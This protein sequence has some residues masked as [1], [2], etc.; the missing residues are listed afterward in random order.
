MITVKAPGKL[1]IA[2]EYAV[3]ETGYPSI[4][5][6]LDQFVTVEISRSKS[7][8]S[9]VSK[10]YRD[11]SVL[12]RRQGDQMILDNRD[13]T[14]NYIISAIRLTEQ[15]AQSLGR[16]MELYDL[17]VNSDLDSPNGKKYGLGSSAAVTVAT[18]KALCQFYQLPLTKSQLF[19][20]AAIAHLDVQ[21]N[22]SLGDIAAS[23]YGGWI[24]YRS[25]DRNWLIAAR[26]QQT[27]T[28][29]VNQPWPHLKITQ[30]T[31]PKN[32]QLIIGWT[33][34]PASTSHLVDKVAI[35]KSR[36][37]QVY[38]QF[39]QDSKNCLEGLIRGFKDGSLDAIKAGIKKNREILQGLADFTHVPIETPTLKKMCDIAVEHTAAA[40]SSGAGGGDCGIVI[41]DKHTNVDSMIERWKQNGITRLSLRV[42][43]VIDLNKE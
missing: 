41:I 9:I 10:Q 36:Q 33:G 6:A 20:L 2:G 32:L 5:V 4:I 12:W 17:K 8:G 23:V 28:Q 27:L 25:F 11:D 31:P 13:N 15:Y 19:K 14:F 3:V 37:H 22:G 35:Q 24:A 1:Y 39:L 16:P 30:L 42:H 38:A 26:N 21:G 43:P 29:L 34:S 7:Y 18:V 40:K